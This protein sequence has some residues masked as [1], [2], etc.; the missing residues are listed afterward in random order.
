MSFLNSGAEMYIHDHC[1]MRWFS[2]LSPDSRVYFYS[3]DRQQ[4]AWK[5]P[6]ISPPP[7]ALSSVLTLDSA[8]SARSRPFASPTSSIEEVIDTDDDADR[9]PSLEEDDGDARAND[10][11]NN[12]DVVRFKGWLTYAKLPYDYPALSSKKSVKKNWTKGEADF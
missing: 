8:D 4:S 11:N 6:T 5:L 1:K 2:G 7:P 9:R 10:A 3:E 12:N